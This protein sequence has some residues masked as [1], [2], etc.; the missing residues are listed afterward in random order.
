ML[1]SHLRALPLASAGGILRRRR[2]GGHA[3]LTIGI[4]PKLENFHPALLGR[5]RPAL[6]Q[7]AGLM[8]R[9]RKRLGFEA[10]DLHALQYRGVRE[11]A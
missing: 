7:V 4:S 10:Y 9:E 2:S 8:G 3:P 6:T 11:L 5:L 1:N